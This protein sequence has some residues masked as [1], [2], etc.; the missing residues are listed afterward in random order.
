MDIRFPVEL[1]QVLVF[2]RAV[3]EPD[4]AYL[5]AAGHD[6]RTPVHAPPTFTQ[7]CA[8]WDPDYWLRPRPGTAWHGSATEAGVMPWTG[9]VL[10]AEQHFTYHRPVVVGDVLTRSDRPGESWQK[11]GRSG[12]LSFSELVSEF[13]DDDGE[14]VV[15]VRAV[16]VVP[17]GVQ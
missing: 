13:R 14:L 16:R 11:V 3:G 8:Q 6:P 9:G 10:H 4:A 5:A 15:T 2:A 1:G 7:A 12:T 17:G